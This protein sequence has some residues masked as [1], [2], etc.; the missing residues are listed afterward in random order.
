M[1]KLRES[2]LKRICEIAPVATSHGVGN[3]YILATQ[4][5]LG[6]PITQ[7]ART[8]IR[9]GE[10][11]EEHIHPTMDEHFFFLEGEC[12]VVI[13]DK[14]FRCVKNDYLCVTA[15]SSHKIEV[16]SDVTMITVGVEVK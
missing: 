3:K 5:E 7:I 16:I 12:S 11:V 13:N 6:K 9:A 10:V 2:I 14:I 1:R 15:G 8:V 4:E